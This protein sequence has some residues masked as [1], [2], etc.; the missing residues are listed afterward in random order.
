MKTERS[1]GKEWFD[2]PKAVL[3][4]VVDWRLTACK[5]V[6]LAGVL[7]SEKEWLA[8]PRNSDCPKRP[9]HAASEGK[10]KR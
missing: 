6:A 2:I 3:R 1:G 10:E 9:G 4:N 8:L 7:L 5:R